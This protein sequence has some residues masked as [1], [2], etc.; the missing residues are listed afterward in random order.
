MAIR[1]DMMEKASAL[2]ASVTDQL[3]TAVVDAKDGTVLKA[4]AS[5]P[6]R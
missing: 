1:D 3:G 6:S 4:R 5:S 2:L